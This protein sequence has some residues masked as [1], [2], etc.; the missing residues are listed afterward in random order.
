ME[1]KNKAGIMCLIGLSAT[2]ILYWESDLSLLLS[3]ILMICIMLPLGIITSKYQKELNK[4][5]K[6]EN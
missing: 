1:R 6:D 2:A 4:K 5:K 3:T